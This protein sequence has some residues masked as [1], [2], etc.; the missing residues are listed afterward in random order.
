MGMIAHSCRIS[1]QISFSMFFLGED[2]ARVSSESICSKTK[3]E[4]LVN[5]LNPHFFPKSESKH[6]KTNSK[7]SQLCF[8]PVICQTHFLSPTAVPWGNLEASAV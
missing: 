5:L 1:I 2:F 3:Q 7:N 8:I 6:V 4:N